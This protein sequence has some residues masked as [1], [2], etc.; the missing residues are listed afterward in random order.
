MDK[1]KQAAIENFQN[2]I[3]G[4]QRMIAAI[5]LLPDGL[6]A[7]IWSIGFDLNVDIPWDVAK[8][9]QIRERLGSDWKLLYKPCLSDQGTL[10]FRYRHVN[11]TFLWIYMQP[12][13]EGSTCRRVQ[14]GEKTVP[15]YKVV[16]DGQAEPTEVAEQTD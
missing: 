1:N 14:V 5:E 11:G 15:V 3:A 10:S 4:Y 7:Y 12:Q 16:C 9:R 6:D 8:L 13:R 2:S